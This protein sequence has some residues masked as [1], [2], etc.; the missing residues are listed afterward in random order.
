MSLLQADSYVGDA[1]DFLL[2]NHFA[3]RTGWLHGVMSLVAEDGLLLFIALIALGWWL[4]RRRDE[5]GRMAAVAWTGL[6]TLAAVGINQPI[7]N[8]V[9][10]ARPYSTIPNVLV[11]VSRTSDY[12]FPSDHATMAGAVAT[13]LLFVSA[14][15]GIAAW[16]AALLLAF[17]RVYVGAHYPHDVVVGLALGAAVVLAGRVVAQPILAALV[18]RLGRTRLRSVLTSANGPNAAHAPG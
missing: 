5:P 15:L 14:R 10:E 12:A 17:S 6:G 13:G 3:R 7:V 16:C 4:A 11:L 8:A 2:I 1:G 18:R 9:H